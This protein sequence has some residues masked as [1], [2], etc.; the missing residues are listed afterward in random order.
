MAIKQELEKREKRTCLHDKHLSLGAMMVSFGGFDMPLFYQNA[1]IAPEHY[2]VR[3]KVGLF[4]VGQENLVPSRF[5][6]VVVVCDAELFLKA[7]IVLKIV[8]QHC[9]KVFWG[10]S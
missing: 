5:L 1:G 8:V 3:E 2:E 7:G 4:D 10:L 6:A 9:V